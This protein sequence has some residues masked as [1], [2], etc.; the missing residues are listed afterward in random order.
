MAV[1]R[2][3]FLTMRW[4]QSPTHPLEHKK[5]AQGRGVALLRFAPGFEDPN[6]CLRSHVLYVISGMLE[7]VLDDRVERV[8]AGE[9]CWVDSGSPH[10]A[11]NPGAEDAIVFIVS[12]VAPQS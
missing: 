6:R 2:V 10:Q 4:E 7:L 8:T 5:V 3:P 9:A 1:T 11:R 12:D